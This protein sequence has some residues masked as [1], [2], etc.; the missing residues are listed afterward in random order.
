[1][2]R[3]RADECEKVAQR[4]PNAHVR[5]TL[6]E[7]Q[8]MW[9]RLTGGRDQRSRNGGPVLVS[10]LPGTRGGPVLINK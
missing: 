10:Y 7:I 8:R 6:A 9:Q 5:D 4:A 3:L 1:M 2:G